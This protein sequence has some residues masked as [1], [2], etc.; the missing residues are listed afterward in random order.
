MPV[1]KRR[2]AGRQ[3]G[4]PIVHAVLQQTLAEL[5]AFGLDGLSVGR[6]ATKAKVNKTSVYRRWPTREALVCAALERVLVDVAA[7]VPDTGSL[8]GDLLG[9]LAPVSE[10]LTSD[11]GKT[12]LRTALA[13]STASSI[14]ELVARQLEQ[15]SKPMLAVVERARARNEWRSGVDPRQLVFLLIGA[16][17]HRTLLE[18]E[19]L[20][21]KWLGEIFDLSL[22]GTY[23]RTR[24]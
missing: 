21:M 18:H 10:L 8:R 20:T 11:V 17:M 7:A 13:E 9:L 4:E 24:N 6:V 19:T 3:R 1:K 22:E 15:T 14:G 2:D 23:P 12:V 5:S 16:C